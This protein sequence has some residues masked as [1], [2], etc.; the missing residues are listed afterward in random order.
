M[1]KAAH[2]LFRMRVLAYRLLMQAIGD[3]DKAKLAMLMLLASQLCQLEFSGCVTKGSER[4][5]QI[6]LQTQLNW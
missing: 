3:N 5:Q 4:E 2:T 1:H 6:S